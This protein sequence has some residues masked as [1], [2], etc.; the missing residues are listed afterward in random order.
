MGSGGSERDKP[1]RRRECKCDIRPS[2]GG[3]DL[4]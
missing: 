2:S 1:L 3:R 4:I